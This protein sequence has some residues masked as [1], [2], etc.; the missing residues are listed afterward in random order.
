MAGSCQRTD[1]VSLSICLTLNIWGISLAG[2]CTWFVAGTGRNYSKDI[3]LP[4]RIG[5]WEIYFFSHDMAD[6]ELLVEWS[7]NE[8]QPTSTV[9]G[10]WITFMAPLYV[11]FFW[12]STELACQWHP[13]M[14]A[15]AVKRISKP[16]ELGARVSKRQGQPHA[17]FFEMMSCMCAPD[18]LI[19]TLAQA[20]MLMGLREKD[21]T[22]QSSLC[23][24]ER[25]NARKYTSEPFM[26]MKR[27]FC[28]LHEILALHRISAILID[29]QTGLPRKNL[30]INEIVS[31]HQSVGGGRKAG[32]LKCS[33]LPL[34]QICELLGALW[35]MTLH[36][37]CHK[38][39]CCA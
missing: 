22:H 12:E 4:E 8:H 5:C 27:S 21:Q 29:D 19:W 18:S 38:E 35:F 15:T 16:E 23:P 7:S 33:A 25:S 37:G 11:F 13:V 28:A 17:G 2:T 14:V 34:E 10:W 30:L 36:G 24:H 32:S 31:L 6:V 1:G 3:T 26:E 20:H 39:K 9:V